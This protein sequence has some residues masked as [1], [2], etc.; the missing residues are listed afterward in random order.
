ML[1]KYCVDSGSPNTCMSATKH[2]TVPTTFDL[3]II[4]RID[5]LFYS[6]YGKLPLL[7][8]YYKMGL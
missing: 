2:I 4:M 7:F 8:V 6:S 5:V 3:G 1:I